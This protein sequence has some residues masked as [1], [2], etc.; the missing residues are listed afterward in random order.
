MTAQSIELVNQGKRNPV[1]IN[2][3]N[4]QLQLF[5]ERTYSEKVSTGESFPITVNY[6][7]TLEQMIADGKYDWLNPDINAKNFPTEGKG[8]AEVDIELVHFN[9]AME[10]NK[11]LKELEK[12]GLRPATLPELLA[13][14][15]KYPEKQREFP[16]VALG[17]VWR[18]FGGEGSVAGLDRDGSER[19]LRL[20]WLGGRWI[21]DD[22]FAAVRK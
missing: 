4:R 12:Q 19:Y 16:I 9:R 6:S 3:L 20:R 18:D 17:S 10:S 21:A 11:V 1:E 2:W 5:K 15:A 7:R 13:F 8:T 22:R 14:G